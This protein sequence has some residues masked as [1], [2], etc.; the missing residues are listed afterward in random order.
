MTKGGKWDLPPFDTDCFRKVGL[1]LVCMYQFIP[2][3]VEVDLHYIAQILP[4]KFYDRPMDL[5]PNH[6]KVDLTPFVKRPQI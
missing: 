5:T 2:F 1:T 6:K 4:G 3:A